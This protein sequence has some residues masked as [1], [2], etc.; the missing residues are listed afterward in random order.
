MNKA[1]L[2]TALTIS[3]F[4]NI[5]LFLLAQSYAEDTAGFNYAVDYLITHP[6]DDGMIQNRYEANEAL[7]Q[8][9]DERQIK[10]ACD[11]TPPPPMKG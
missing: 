10:R 6:I 2:P 3:I 7:I 8:L 11:L 1:I 9:M 5:V 4:A